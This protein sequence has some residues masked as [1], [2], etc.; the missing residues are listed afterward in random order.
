[1]FGHLKRTHIKCDIYSEP[2]KWTEMSDNQILNTDN[3]ELTMHFPDYRQS[4]TNSCRDPYSTPLVVAFPKEKKLCIISHLQVYLKRTTPFRKDSKQL[5]LSDLK[6]HGPV[7]KDTISKWCKSMLSSEEIDTSKFKGHSTRAASS[8]HL[9][10]NN[11][12]IK[13]I[14]LSA[15]WSNEKTFQQCYH[16]PS[17]FEFNFGQEIL[18]TLAKK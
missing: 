2:P 13:D 4:E 3:M 7:R 11:I 6:P 5:L 1:M 8:S 16:K 10:G 17:D 15:G 14:M 18:R 9:V 12:N